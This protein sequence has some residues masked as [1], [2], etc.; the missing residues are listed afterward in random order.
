MEIKRYSIT[1]IPGG[2]RDY[3]NETGEY[4]KYADLEV[5]IKEIIRRVEDNPVTIE[6]P[7]RIVV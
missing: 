4:V 2:F 3:E 5:K 1:A 7:K 6:M